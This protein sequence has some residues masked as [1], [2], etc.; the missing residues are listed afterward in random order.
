[1]ISELPSRSRASRLPLCSP[2]RSGR[3]R[4]RFP[5]TRLLD[6]L[7]HVRHVQGAVVGGVA[8]ELSHGLRRTKTDRTTACRLAG[9]APAA[10]V[11]ATPA[12][13]QAST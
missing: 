2:T 6:R 7:L 1:M 11:S 5:C 10:C 8:L 13:A 12:L 9:P 4:T 3:P